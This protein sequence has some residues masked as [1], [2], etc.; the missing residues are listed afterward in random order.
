MT[1]DLTPEQPA[2]T[3]ADA[4]A[5]TDPAITIV[6]TFISIDGDPLRIATRPDGLLVIQPGG[7]KQIV[8][9]KWQAMAMRA[10]L[11]VAP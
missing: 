4:P 6:G 10:A 9:D 3:Q 5:S 11:A 2:D 7:R 8:L 1:L